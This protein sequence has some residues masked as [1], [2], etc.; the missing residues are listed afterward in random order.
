MK[1][2]N[3]VSGAVAAMAIAFGLAFAAPV[4]AADQ[5]PFNDQQN[6]SIQEVIHQYIL[7]HPEVIVEAMQKLQAQQQQAEEQRLRDAAQS[8][9]PVAAE[10]HV[11]GDPAAPVKVIEFSDFECPFCKGFHATMK[12]VMGDYEKDGKVAWVYRHFPIDELHPRARKEAQAAECANELG[13]N[14]AFWD[15]ADKLFE[16]TPSNNRLDPAQLPQIA[17]AVGLDK[18][19]FDSCLDGSAKFAAHIEANIQDATASGGQGT[20]YSVV[21]TPNGKVVPINGAQPYEEVKA[22]IDTA[23]KAQ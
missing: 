6:K 12:Q 9:K 10:D 13:G 8:V 7:D 21:I 1:S 14:K 20:P 16:V 11:R 4:R 3:R 23:L 5:S 18:A 2:S 22:V 17:E 15:Y 19:K